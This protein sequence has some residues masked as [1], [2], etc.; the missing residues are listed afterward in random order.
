MTQLKPTFGKTVDDAG[1]LAAAI[2]LEKD[3]VIRPAQEVHTG[4]T[5]LIVPLATRK[6]VDAAVLDRAKVDAGLTAAR[7]PRRGLFGVSTGRGPEDAAADSPLLGRGGIG[8]SA[9][10]SAAGT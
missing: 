7:V 2:G 8:D 3:A 4:S 10:R 9:N 6:A 1:G 5:F